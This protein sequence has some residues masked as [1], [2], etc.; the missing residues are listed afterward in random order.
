MYKAIINSDI[1][2][3]DNINIHRFNK[4]DNPLA[5]QIECDLFT[6]HIDR[7]RDNIEKL[8][9]MDFDDE[10]YIRFICKHPSNKIKKRVGVGEE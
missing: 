7:A 4:E 9:Y 6:R 5:S 3:N 2:Y 1:T 10:R 8:R